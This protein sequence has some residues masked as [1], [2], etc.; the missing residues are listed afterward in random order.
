MLTFTVRCFFE[1]TA[2]MVSPACSSTCTTATGSDVYVK[3]N[4]APYLLALDLAH[5]VDPTKVTARF[6]AGQLELVLQKVRSLLAVHNSDMQ[7]CSDD[8]TLATPFSCFLLYR[9]RQG[10]GALTSWC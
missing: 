6:R 5:E 7:L 8:V 10:C 3:V 1:A 4:Y 9:P 2:I